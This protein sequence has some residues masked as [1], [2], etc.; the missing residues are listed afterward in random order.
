MK[1]VVVI[2]AGFAG[3]AAALRARRAGADVTVLEALPR[4]GGKAALGWADFS[5]GPT[6]VTM[7]QVLSALHERVGLPR[8]HFESAR[9][10]TTYSY[11][12]GRTFA[13]GAL[14]VEGDLDGTLAQL[15]RTEGQDYLRLLRLAR[16][17]YQDAQDTFLFAPPPSRTALLR[18]ALTRG[19][20]ASPGRSLASLVQSGPY[21]TPFWLRFATYLGADPYR[22]PAVLHN[23]SW[24]ELGMGV[25]HLNG[26]AG[27]PPGQARGLGAL[28]ARLAEHAG[29]LGVRF[30]YRTRVEHLVHERVAPGRR[31]VYAAHTG[32]GVF[33]ADVFV[34]A[35]D[36]DHTLGWLGAPPS[37]RPLGLSG[38][39]LQLR[40]SEALPAAHHLLF[41]QD[42]AREWQELR[43]GQLPTDPTLY[44]HLD[45]DRAFF[46]VNAPPRPEL[47]AGRDEYARFLLW[48][49]Q[50][51]LPLPVRE[52]RALSPAEYARV[53]RGGA[54]YGSAPHGLAGALRPGWRLGSYDNLR[55][56]GGT[57][58]PGGGVPLSL[59]SGWNG[60]GE[61]LSL[62]YDDLGGRGP[63]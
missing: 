24:V 11:A 58:H 8:P 47:G 43:A 1:R 37:P 15:S 5:S 28:A 23:I 38:F 41:S 17:L 60:A 45:G 52:W 54:I 63:W 22:A 20:R 57:V 53:A 62:P 6:V 19:R 48:R 4:A 14:A 18:Y 49:L 46:L 27:G 16:T 10:T 3:L 50:E 44:L 9:P 25:W 12:D 42:Y 2:G 30:E 39:A 36:R 51:R 59:L 13:P 33:S 34:S 31:L 29:M 40:L 21:L 7:P 61:L 56:V 55:Q 26:W 35:A 32:R